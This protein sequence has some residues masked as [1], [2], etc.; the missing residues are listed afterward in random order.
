MILRIVFHY[1][2]IFIQLCLL[3]NWEISECVFS[4]SNFKP[5]FLKIGADGHSTLQYLGDEIS[6]L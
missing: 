2:H 4:K 5:S 6:R 3:F 1:F